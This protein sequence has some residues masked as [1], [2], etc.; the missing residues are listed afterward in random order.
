MSHDPPADQPTSPGERGRVAVA[1]FGFI[2]IGIMAGAGGVLLPDQIADYGVSKA[3]I[4]VIFIAFPVGYVT[5]AATNGALVHRLGARTVLVGGAGVLVAALVA[6]GLRPPFAVFVAL[7]AGV[8]LG[9]GAMEAALNAYLSTLA[10]ATRLLNTLH[11]FFGVG[12]L[13]GPLVAVAVLGILP[14]Y[15]FYYLLAA[16]VVALLVLLFVMYPPLVARPTADVERPRLSAALAHPAVWVVGVFL[17]VYVGLELA[18]G[19]WAFT[20]L[21]EVRDRSA[22]AAGWVVSGYWMGLTAGRLVLARL[23]DRIGLGVGGLL[24]GWNRG[25]LADHL[26]GPVAG[27]GLGRTG[28]ARLLPRAAV[29]DH[30]R[31]HA[32]AGPGPARRYGHRG[33]RRGQFRRVAVPVAGRRGGRALRRLVH[34]PGGG[35][36]DR[37]AERHVVVDRRPPA[38]RRRDVSGAVMTAEG[39][40]GRRRSGRS[41]QDRSRRGLTT[42]GRPWRS[43]SRSN[44]KP[45]SCSTTVRW[46]C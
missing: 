46:R 24:G 36:A 38:D 5:A 42:G 2:L 3:T 13:L 12:A 9:I 32:P 29:P 4:G 20:Y 28:P 37:P 15:G 39:A 21:L 35:R 16:V 7:Q 43:R 10:A 8:G 26:A 18:V 27:A 23:A 41:R 34:L 44:R 11:A 14:W 31:R 6:T 22:G 45:P 30:H 1:Y 17:A 33:G 19:N 25:R 40:P